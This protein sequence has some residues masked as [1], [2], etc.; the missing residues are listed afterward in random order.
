MHHPTFT[1]RQWLAQSAAGAA[2]LALAPQAWAQ[3][4]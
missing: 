4:D 3:S 2:A 1:R